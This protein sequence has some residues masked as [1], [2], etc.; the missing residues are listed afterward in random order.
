MK[1]DSNVGNT[2]KSGLDML[3]N[4]EDVNN[5]TKHSEEKH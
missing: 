3:F 5:I 2:Q 4:I 1:L